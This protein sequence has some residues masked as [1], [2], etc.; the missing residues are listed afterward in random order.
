M[1]TPV[2][3]TFSSSHCPARSLQFFSRGLLRA[4]GKYYLPCADVNKTMPSERREKCDWLSW[5]YSLQWS[6]CECQCSLPCGA[7]ALYHVMLHMCAHTQLRAPSLSH[8]GHWLLREVEESMFC[9]V[10]FRSRAQSWLNQASKIGVMRGW[11]TPSQV[12]YPTLAGS[13]CC[14][15]AGLMALPN[16]FL[17]M[18]LQC[19]QSPS[20]FKFA[21]GDT[22]PDIM[23]L[24]SGVEAPEGM[25]LP[26]AVNPET[27][28]P[29]QGDI[30]ISVQA[31]FW[32]GW[33]PSRTG[34]PC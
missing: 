20:W 27:R 33:N 30:Y 22:F 14:P 12:Q 28:C 19:P 29:H 1:H 9:F 34:I 4:S 18:D 25:S 10:F 5:I 6:L 2:E 32:P 26:H 16:W 15:P 31:C 11:V 13:S 17:Q 7:A 23:S 24:R 3:L 8:P 21:L